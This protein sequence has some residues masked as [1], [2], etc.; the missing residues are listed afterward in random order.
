MKK[1]IFI[2]VLISISFTSVLAQAAFNT[3]AFAVEKSG[4]GPVVLFIPG[5]ACSGAVWQETVAALSQNY[6][7]HVLTLAGFAGQPSLEQPSLQTVR[8][9]IIRYIKANNLE[10]PILIGHSLGGFLSMWI[11]SLQPGLLQKVLIVDSL[12]FLSAAMMPDITQAQ[13]KAQAERMTQMMLAQNEEQY[14]V[15]QK[16]T[17]RNMITETDDQITALQWSLASD[18]P[19]VAAAMQELMTTDLR[20]QIATVEI[21]MLVLGAWY[22]G[23]D[24]GMT[25][26]S[27]QQLYE[28][29]YAK[30][31]NCEVRMAATAK[32]F[33]MMDEFDW[34]LQEVTSFLEQQ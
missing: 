9:E 3:K 27:T 2:L 33:I 28:A 18:R 23:K 4:Q 12:P 5:L 7:C 32:H 31:P 1:I 8:D 13:A 10:Q 17:L 16:M 24:Y 29:Q 34:Y 14:A 6:E 19:T 21:P 11:A 15:G 20:E 26:A 22:A 30:A 25:E